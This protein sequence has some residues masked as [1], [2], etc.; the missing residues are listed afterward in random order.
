M[1][2]FLIKETKELKT[3]EAKEWRS[4]HYLPDCFDELEDLKGKYTYNHDEG[5]YEI[6]KEDFENMVDWW[7]SEFENWKQGFADSGEEFEPLEV[8]LIVR[9]I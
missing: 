1:T 7:E 3:V 2:K 8:E 5:Y 4:D 9:T 6:S